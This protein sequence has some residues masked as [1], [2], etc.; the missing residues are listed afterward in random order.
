MPRNRGKED[1]VWGGKPLGKEIRMSRWSSDSIPLRFQTTSFTFNN[2][3]VG[4]RGSAIPTWWNLS[5]IP[6]FRRIGKVIANHSLSMYNSWPR[7]AW[8]NTNLVT[9]D[10]C[11]TSTSPYH[12]TMSLTRSLNLPM[13]QGNSA[14]DGLPPHR[15]SLLDV[16]IARLESCSRKRVIHPY[17]D[18]PPANGNLEEAHVAQLRSYSVL[19]CRKFE[20][21][22]VGQRPQAQAHCGRSNATR[23]GKSNTPTEFNQRTLHAHNGRNQ[24]RRSLRIT[25]RVNIQL[26]TYTIMISPG[27]VQS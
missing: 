27:L 2:W 26:S 21:F 19:S 11:S 25:N 24:A 22:L 14:Y 13:L 3:L 12:V 1:S 7:T 6:L 23:K 15:R 9:C 4:K 10:R 17:V 16:T 8:K 20:S 5:K 18:S